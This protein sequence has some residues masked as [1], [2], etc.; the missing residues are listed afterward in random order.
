M[1]QATFGLAAHLLNGF[2]PLDGKSARSFQNEADRG[3]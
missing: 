1:Q 3:R 2:I